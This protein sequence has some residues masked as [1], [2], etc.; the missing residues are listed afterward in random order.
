MDLICQ[1]LD[2]AVTLGNRVRTLSFVSIYMVGY[3]LYY[4]AIYRYIQEDRDILFDT[5]TAFAYI[6]S[7]LYAF[8][9][10]TYIIPMASIEQYLNAVV[11]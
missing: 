10:S 6:I 8:S 2:I 7:Y 4:M 3:G 5:I 11:V 1:V 9:K